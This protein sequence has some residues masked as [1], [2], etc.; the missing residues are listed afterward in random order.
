MTD[1]EVV[2]VKLIFAPERPMATSVEIRKRPGKKFDADS[3]RCPLTPRESGV[4]AGAGL[5]FEARVVDRCSRRIFLA[6][7]PTIEVRRDDLPL[8]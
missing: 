5:H 2:Q 6:F 8:E 3:A 1:Q 4:G 7:E